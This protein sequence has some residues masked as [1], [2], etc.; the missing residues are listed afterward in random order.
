MM[1]PR[2][3]VVSRSN[4]SIA[5]ARAL[6]REGLLSESHQH[7]ANAFATLL[8]SW[9]PESPASEGT[10]LPPDAEDRAI[11]A[12]EAAGYPRIARL[13]KSIA[14]I[15][16]LDSGDVMSLGRVE[17]IWTEIE[18][19][20][21]FSRRRFRS[22][23]DAKRLLVR[24]LAVAGV[25]TLAMIAALVA[26]WIRPRIDASATF[27]PEQPPSNAFDGVD[28]TE[29]LL[30]DGVPGWVE[31]KFRS[32]RSIRNVRVANV[33]NRY[34]MDRASERVRVTAYAGQAVVGTA[35]RRFK[36]IVEQRSTQD[37]KLEASGVTRLRVEVLSFFGRGGGFAEIDLR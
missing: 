2:E 6:Y 26:L 35:E 18:R 24:R 20:A 5:A 25:A 12:I 19:L 8:E 27:S 1:S 37:F 15:R 10:A 36:G 23:A 17:S 31:L 22:P 14:A 7:M 33:H 29:W 11:A 4:R 30:P 28:S 9:R 3:Q 32:P 16:E 34:Y 13:R 21:R